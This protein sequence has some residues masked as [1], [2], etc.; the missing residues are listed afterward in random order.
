[1]TDNFFEVTKISFNSRINAE[2]D[3]LWNTE[4]GINWPSGPERKSWN[5][6]VTTWSKLTDHLFR[7]LTETNLLGGTNCLSEKSSTVRTKKDFKKKTLTKCVMLSFA[8]KSKRVTTMKLYGNFLE[9][10]LVK[11]L[12]QNSHQLFFWEWLNSFR[13]ACHLI[14]QYRFFTWLKCMN[15][16]PGTIDGPTGVPWCLSPWSHEKNYKSF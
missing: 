5:W 2:M 11:L 9:R 1:M 7:E 4:R 14:K 6:S 10:K 8:L 12:F 16:R 15:F 3:C 13:P